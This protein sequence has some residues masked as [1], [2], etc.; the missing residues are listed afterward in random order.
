MSL[1]PYAR[2]EWLSNSQDHFINLKIFKE[3]SNLVCVDKITHLQFKPEKKTFN[4]A[5]Y[6]NHQQP[7]H[8]GGSFL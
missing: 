6:Q 7:Q 3:K 8:C 2:L 4:V 1:C 5:E